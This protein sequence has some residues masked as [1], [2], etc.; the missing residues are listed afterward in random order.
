MSLGN[1]Q[2]T[3]FNNIILYEKHYHIKNL[4]LNALKIIFWLLKV[5]SAKKRS[6]CGKITLWK[7]H[8]AT[9]IGEITLQH[10]FAISDINSKTESS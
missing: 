6:H 3:T 5:N 7:V 4:L 1:F 10:T 2:K 8:V 9:T